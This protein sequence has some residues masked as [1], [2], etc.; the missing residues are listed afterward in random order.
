L[1]E[2]ETVERV[3][4]VE[5]AGKRG[6]VIEEDGLLS[7]VVD[8]HDVADGV[9]GVAQRLEQLA[10]GPC[11]VDRAQAAGGRFVAELRA[12]AVA[13]VDVTLPLKSYV[14]VSEPAASN[15]QYSAHRRFFAAAPGCTSPK[16]WRWLRMRVPPVS[17][18]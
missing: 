6:I 8:L 17:T 14:C 3:V 12:D 1:G 11:R 9:V 10:V 18:N 16:T 13:V 5:C 4:L 7:R 15:V 2:R